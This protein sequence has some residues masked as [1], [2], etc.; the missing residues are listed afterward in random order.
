MI[1]KIKDY[2]YMGKGYIDVHYK[3]VL[4]VWIF[5]K[6]QGKKQ[7]HHSEMFLLP[8]II[9]EMGVFILISMNSIF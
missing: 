6:M 3:K 8:N 9:L 5:S 4:Y 2:A 7:K 1:R